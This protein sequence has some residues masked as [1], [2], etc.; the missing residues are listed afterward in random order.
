MIQVFARC[1]ETGTLTLS[2]PATG[3]FVDLRTALLSK[4]PMLATC[5]DLVGDAL[6]VCIFAQGFSAPVLEANRVISQR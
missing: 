4:R 3:S 1:G 6:A 2:V 5:T